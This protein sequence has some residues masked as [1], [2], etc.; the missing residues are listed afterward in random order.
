MYNSPSNTIIIE[1]LIQ[2]NSVYGINVDSDVSS[3]TIYHNVF[4]YN[5]DGSNPQ[6]LDFNGICFWYNYTLEEGNFW[7]DWDGSG[8][9]EIAGPPGT[10][11]PFPLSEEV[12]ISTTT[13]ETT[14]PSG[15][16]TETTDPTEKIFLPGFSY[17]L[18]FSWIIVTVYRRK[19]KQ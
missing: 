1:N 10:N 4:K 15:N 16:T 9:Y 5:G 3:I 8:N 12:S 18:I 19:Q 2:S 13:P 6:A 7:S 14:D 11:D 17:L